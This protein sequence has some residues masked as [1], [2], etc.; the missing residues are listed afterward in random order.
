MELDLFPGSYEL[1]D[2]IIRESNGRTDRP[3]LVSRLARRVD[4]SRTELDSALDLLTRAGV[5]ISTHALDGAD[6]RA[7]AI[8]PTGLQLRE[9]ERLVG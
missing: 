8:T 6:G 2:A 5:V 4:W 9:R 3:V 7:V 1:L